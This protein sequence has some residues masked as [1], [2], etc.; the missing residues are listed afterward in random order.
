MEIRI[1][2]SCTSWFENQEADFPTDGTL[3]QWCRSQVVPG[4]Q[5]GNYLCFHDPVS[6]LSGVLRGGEYEST[7][8]L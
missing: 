2:M 5:R 1:V 4:V 3:T 8:G 6:R 7:R